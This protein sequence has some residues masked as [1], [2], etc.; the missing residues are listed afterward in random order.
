MSDQPVRT[1]VRTQEAGWRAFQEFMIAQRARGELAAL[2]FRGRADAPDRRRRPSRRSRERGRSSSARPT[3][4]ISIGPILALP[5]MREALL[6]AHAPVVAVSPIVAGR[7]PQGP[8]RVLHGA[9][10]GA[11]A[12]PTGS[13]RSTATCSTGSS[14]TKS[15]PDS[16]A[17]VDTLMGDADG[18]RRLAEQTL[19][20]AATLAR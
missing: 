3:R 4:S 20:F 9:S 18:R 5:G 14:P 19:S 2:E 13:P 16:R 15:S 6:A 12:A 17:C 7:G 10:P 1:W 8:D 11:S